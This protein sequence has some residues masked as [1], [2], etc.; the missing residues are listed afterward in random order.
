VDAQ[1]NVFVVDTLNSRV[2]KFDKA[3]NFVSMF[4]GP[5]RGDGLFRFD[6]FGGLAIDKQGNVY[7]ANSDNTQR[8]EPGGQPNVQVFDNNGTFLRKFGGTAQADGGLNM[9]TDLVMD[10]KGNVYVLDFWRNRVNKYDTGGHLLKWWASSTVD[11]IA[12][13]SIDNIYVTSYTTN[14]V[15]KYD[16]EGTTLESQVKTTFVHP[17]GITIDRQD[18]IYVTDGWA[19]TGPGITPAPRVQK[20][21]KYGR[22]TGTIGGGPASTAE[23]QL[24][25]P[26]YLTVDGDGYLYISDQHNSAVLKFR[27]K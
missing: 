1:G 11:N 2:Q 16:S 26:S 18:N 21:D 12:I 5:G 14:S 24:N 27:Q 19:V 20:F 15:L 10:S 25:G 22:L 17:V 8:G 6:E 4:G 7:V 23:G 9:P 13:D 3:G